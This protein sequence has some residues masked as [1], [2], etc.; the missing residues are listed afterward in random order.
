VIDEPHESGILREQ[1]PDGSERWYAV[2]PKTGLRVEIAP[3]QTWFWTPEWQA[4]ER[5]AD[6]DLAHGRYEVF[7]D[8]DS[9]IDSL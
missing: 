1:A 6:E 3:Q 5:Q 8:L 4:R 2:H 7:D 9:F